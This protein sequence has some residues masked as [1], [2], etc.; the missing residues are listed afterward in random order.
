MRALLLLTMCL[1]VQGCGLPRDPSGTLRRI[2]GGV[3]RV[4]VVDNPPWVI[5]RGGEPAGVEPAIVRTLAAELGAEVQWTRGAEHDL[6]RALHTR[7]LDLAI[8]G[9]DAKLPWVR[10]AALTRPYYRDDR[11]HVFA[12]PPGENAWM[13][14]VERAL[15]THEPDVGHLLAEAARP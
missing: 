3:L 6:M 2:T 11:Q 1:V 8:G 14:R 7:S 13:V 9:F 5:A 4:G 12:V 15:H 10:E